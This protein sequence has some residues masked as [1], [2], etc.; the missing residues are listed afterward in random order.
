MVGV[1]ASMIDS[2]DDHCT[3]VH[4]VNWDAFER[5][6]AERGDSKPRVAYL[7]GTLEVMSPS[8]SHEL[9]KSRI[10]TLLEEYVD[11]LGLTFEG[12]GAWLLKNAKGQAG[13]EPDECY[14]LHE[15]PKGRPDLAIEVVW[16]SGGID[17]LEIYRRLG[18][19]E[20]WFWIDERVDV[21]VLVNETYVQADKSAALPSFPFALIPELLDLPSL[22]AVRKRVREYLAAL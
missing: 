20:V 18:V 16:R 1:L 5:F 12:L 4:G 11:H 14:I 9:I 2:P 8:G 6:L 3:V 7:E 21:F 17:K 13:L 10:R 15:V 22:S 19:P